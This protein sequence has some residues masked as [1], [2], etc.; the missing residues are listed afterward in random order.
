MT[1]IIRT[2]DLYFNY[3]ELIDLKNRA[4]P[5]F[6][7]G[8]LQPFFDLPPTSRRVRVAASRSILSDNSVRFQVKQG[9]KGS[10]ALWRRRV[11]DSWNELYDSLEPYIAQLGIA[12]GKTGYIYIEVQ[13][14]SDDIAGW[15]SGRVIRGF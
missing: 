2:P 5:F 15:S 9:M 4:N 1:G 3:G 12:P 11:G 10:P 8:G 6:C 13:A 7:P 14:W